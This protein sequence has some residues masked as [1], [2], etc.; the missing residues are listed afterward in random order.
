MVVVGVFHHDADGVA[1][2]SL[3]LKKEKIDRIFFSS[4]GRLF[5]TLCKIALE[6]DQKDRIYIC[7]L[8]ANQES[9]YVSATFK[10]AIWIDHH[11]WENL[12]IPKNVKVYVKHYNSAAK[13]LAEYLGLEDE[14]VDIVEQVDSN[15]IQ[16][17]E[18]RMFRELIG[19]IKWKFKANQYP[20]LIEIAKEIAE[21][22]IKEVINKYKELIDEYIKWLNSN[23][24]HILL[25]CK[26]YEKDKNKVLI[27][28][29]KEQI[30]SYFVT[31]VINNKVEDKFDYIFIVYEGQTTRIEIRT[32]T[33]KNCYEIAKKL[34]GGGHYIAAGATLL[35]V[36][37]DEEL[38]NII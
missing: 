16:T 12:E 32:Q 31:E 5:K 1:C 10:E 4:P 27:V 17:E 23:I 35:S 20:Y 11:V 19:M 14:I 21:K 37:T 24:L 3:L 18:A 15:N 7:D 13:V 8:S 36:P 29:L 34:G 22:G 2:L 38:L 6:M 25:N 9:I 26:F 30:P 33:G 28:R